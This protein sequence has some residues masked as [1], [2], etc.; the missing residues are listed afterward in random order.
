MRRII[1]VALLSVLLIVS[2]AVGQELS[3]RP[4]QAPSPPA[5]TAPNS[6]PTYQ[7][8]RQSQLGHVT[9]A[10]HDLLLQR[11]AGTFTFRSGTFSFLAPVN[12]K[13]TGAVFL[14]KAPSRWRRPR[15]ASSIA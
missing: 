5:A 1:L 10:V 8:L 14:E 9:L 13:A 4:P 12:G 11:D 2:A 15:P 7:Q 3:S 6:D